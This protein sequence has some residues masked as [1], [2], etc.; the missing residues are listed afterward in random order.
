MPRVSIF[1][2]P[3]HRYQG[4]V[5]D[6]GR[7]K[8]EAARVRLAAMSGKPLIGISDGNVMEFLARGEKVT[9]RIIAA[10]KARKK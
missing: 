8:F 7:D 10:T 6:I 3:I 5:S 1:D 2:N 9:A 4:N